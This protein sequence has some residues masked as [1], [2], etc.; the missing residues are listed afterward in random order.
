M[1]GNRSDQIGLGNQLGT[2]PTH[3]AGEGWHHIR[4]ISMFEAQNQP[5]GRLGID[6]DSPSPGEVGEIPEATATQG[7]GAGIEFKRH[8]AAG[9]LRRGNKIDA[10]PAYRAQYSWLADH[11][12]AAQALWGQQGIQRQPTHPSQD[13]PCVHH[14]PP[15]RLS[16]YITHMSDSVQIFDRRALRHHRD[17]AA[18]GLVKHDFLFRE[19]ADRLADRLLDITRRFPR[20]LDLGCHGGELREALAGRGGIEHMVESDPSEGLARR[21]GGVVVDEE[22]LPFAEQSLDLVASNLAL[23]WVNDLPGCLAQIRRILKPDGLFLATMLGGETLIEL[24]RAWMEAE[25]AEEGGVSPRVA[26]FADLRDLGGLLQRAGFALPV[27]DSE[28]ITVSYPDAMRL[29]V[30]LRGMG[31]ANTVTGRRK[32]FTRRATLFQM[33]NSY[34]RLF[35]RSDGRLPATFQVI[36][37]TAWAPH[38][39]QQPPLKPGSG[40]VSLVDFLGG[41]RPLQDQA[42]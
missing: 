22:L 29:M 32:S 27:V 9:T 15:C 37:L 17:R 31:E 34:E 30:D 8:A 36:T 28:T 6:K 13:T 20:A 14:L 38:A 16:V 5:L 39:S 35:A 33:I 3:P 24:R 19:T 2:G 12:T 21:A 23:H 1:Q 40:Q 25:L 42:P 11:L 26:P 7:I 10:L 41:G 4:A 18:P